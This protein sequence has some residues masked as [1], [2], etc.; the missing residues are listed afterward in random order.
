MELEDLS[1]HRDMILRLEEILLA[2]LEVV[3]LYKESAGLA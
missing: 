1:D 2:G 3:K